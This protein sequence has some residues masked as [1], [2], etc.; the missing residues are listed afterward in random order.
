MALTVLLPGADCTHAPTIALCGDVHQLGP[1]LASSGP[2][3]AELGQSLLERL[4]A[5]EVY[6]RHPR[7]RHYLRG[8]GDQPEPYAADDVEVPFVNLFDKC[9]GRGEAALRLAAIAVIRF[10]SRS[11]RHSSTP[12]L[13]G[14]ARGPRSSARRSCDLSSCR[15]RGRCCSATARRTTSAS[16]KARRG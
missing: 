16:T 4:F 3:S 1:T 5:R 13:C 14:Y 9:V 11:P 6:A 2:L 12:T 7:A 8:R 15:G 10:C